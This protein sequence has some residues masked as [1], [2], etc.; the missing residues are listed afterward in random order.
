MWHLIDIFEGRRESPADWV[1]NALRYLNRGRLQA[2]ASLE[3]YLVDWF[4]HTPGLWRQPIADIGHR[5]GIDVSD[6][7]VVTVGKTAE[8][9]PDYPSANKSDKLDKSLANNNENK[10]FIIRET[11]VGAAGVDAN[12]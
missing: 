6:L 12:Y 3:D 9:Y 8:D 4:L 5:F 11:P 1:W 7:A 10:V 2:H